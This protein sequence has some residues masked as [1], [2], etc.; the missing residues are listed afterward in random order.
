MILLKAK[1]GTKRFGGLIA[2]DAVD[3]EIAPGEIVSLIGP[4]GS[5]KTTFFHC[6]TGFYRPDA[7]LTGLAPHVVD[8]SAGIVD[9]HLYMFNAVKEF[10]RWRRA[11]LTS[12][13]TEAPA[14]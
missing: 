7:L 11:Y 10:E 6:L 14:T 3:L 9:L 13:R 4:N 12:L 2:V 5:G 8:P 1:Q